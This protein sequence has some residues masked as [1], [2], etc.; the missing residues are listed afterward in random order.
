M[1]TMSDYGLYCTEAQTRKAL[2]LGAPIVHHENA[3]TTNST[4][5]FYIGECGNYQKGFIL[6]IIPTAEEMKG[7]LEEQGDIL[8][9][10]IHLYE[11]DGYPKMCGYGF[12][13]YNKNK[14]IIV[15]T[16]TEKGSL[17]YIC[18]KCKE[19]IYLEGTYNNFLTKQE[20]T[21]E[22][23]DAA[24]EYLSCNNDLIK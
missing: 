3:C 19:Y 1:K 22:A 23:I 16:F 15:G 9:I 14:D 17:V 21:L 4:P 12:T 11:D 18:P 2:E 5:H 13:I 24:L 7:W 20:A 6:Y 8:Y 10:D